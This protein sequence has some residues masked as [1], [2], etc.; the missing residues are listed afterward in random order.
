M[1]RYYYPA[2]LIATLGTMAFVIV[3]DLLDDNHAVEASSTT[4]QDPKAPSAPPKVVRLDYATLM[5]KYSV[6]QRH[7]NG[8]RLV[9]LDLSFD[10]NDKKGRKSK[11]RFQNLSEDVQKALAIFLYTEDGRS[12]W[13]IS[14]VIPMAPRRISRILRDASAA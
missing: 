7:G 9:I 4:A 6:E 3:R 13:Q 5:E 12:P 10:P 14:K 8:G 11:A 2:I 1:K